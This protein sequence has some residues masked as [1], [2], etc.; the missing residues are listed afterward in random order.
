MVTVSALD[1]QGRFVPVAG[2]EVRFALSGPGKIIGVGN[3]DPS[4]HEPDKF[5]EK[6]PWKRSL[7]NGLAQVIVQ[8]GREAGALELRS[9]AD[10]LEAGVVGMKL[11]P[12]HPAA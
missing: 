8:A 12:S 1:A 7:F 5:P 9:E 6:E 11:Q 2:N 3:G 4:C 10:G